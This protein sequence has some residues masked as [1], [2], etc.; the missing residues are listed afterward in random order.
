MIDYAKYSFWMETSGDDLSPRPALQRSSDVDVAILGGGYSGLWTAYY[1]LR[2]NPALRVAL[3]EKEI[4]GFG[5]SG[6]NG[7]WCS[8]RFPVTP[9]ML[10][11][12]YGRKAARDLLL[13]MYSAVDEVG[14]VCQDEKIGADFHK[15]GILSLARGS[16][17]LPLIQASYSAYERLGLADRYELLGAQQATERVRVTNLRGAL[18]T[19]EGA[20]L[21]PGKLVRG[22]ARAVERLGGVIYE[23][24]E[25]TDFRPGSLITPGGELRA[26]IAI[27]LAGESYLSRLRRLRRCLLP[28]YSLITLTEPLTPEEWAAIGW[29]NRES[30]ASNRYTVDY[31]TRTADGRILFGSRGAPYVFG[32][33]ITDEQDMHEPTHA[34]LHRTLVEW[35]PELAGIKFTHNWGGP[36]GVPR[37]WMPSVMFDPNARIGRIYG[38]TGQ[39]V[40]TSNLA[41]RLM[42]G[43]ITGQQTGLDTLPLAHRQS[44]NWEWEPLR[45]LVVRYMQTSILRI[46]KNLEEGRSRPWDAWVAEYL[47]RH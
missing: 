24:T 7:G 15:G 35:F 9:G 17:Q 45:W 40:A 20:S 34:N 16:H 5:A 28:M 14:R 38:Y 3:L 31:L 44:P 1:I 23:Q 33:K 13:A 32:S 4:V 25:V 19:P 43:L 37:D 2:A 8:S 29:G 46:D 12:R 11:E 21:N 42:A 27:L 41:A 26:R 39:G 10:Q 36:V 18:Y 47:L 22:L 6:R 30:V